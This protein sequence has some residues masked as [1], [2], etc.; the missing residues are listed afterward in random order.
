VLVL[1]EAADIG[2]VN[3]DDTLKLFEFIAASFAEPVQDEP[4]RLLRDANFL[5]ELHRGYALA[6]RHKQIHRV[7]PL[8]QR[9]MATLEYRA[10]AYRKVFLA[11]VATVEAASAFSDPLAK[12][13]NR[14]A[15]AVRPKPSFKVCPG[16]LLVREHLEK[17]ERGNGALG[18][19]SALNFWVKR[20]RKKRGSQVYKPLFF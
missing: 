6:G 1:F 11:L 17:L 4:S 20:A 14:A 16:R 2:F 12:A 19:R 5:G 13:T 8:V 9:N 18:H 7:N 15:R 10:G 3:L